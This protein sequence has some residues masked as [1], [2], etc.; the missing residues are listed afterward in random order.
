MKRLFYILMSSVLVLLTSCE[1][2]MMDYEGLEGVYFAVQWGDSWGNEKSW[3]YMPYTNVN[4]LTITGNTDTLSLKVM[5]TGPT[6]DYDRTLEVEV[7]PDS[8]TAVEGV[9]YLPIQRKNI[10]KA[11]DTYTYV[12]V[13]L[14]RTADLQSKKLTLGLRLVANKDFDLSFPEWAAVSGFSSG[15]IIKNFNASLHTINFYD[16]IT[17]PKIW[18]GTDVS[19]YYDGAEA[20]LWGAFTRKKFE[21]MCSFFDLTYND[22]NSSETMPMVLQILIYNKM[23]DYLVKCYNEKKPVLEDDGRLMWVSDC[24]WTSK[25]GVPWVPDENYYN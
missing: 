10:V 7:N 1:K 5:V 25:I 12:P 23:H 4:F 24:P 11:G 14:L 16:M 9:N 18:S 6:K 22:F 21:L 2:D 13:I 17:R 15:T 19:P 3:P 20:G 8:T